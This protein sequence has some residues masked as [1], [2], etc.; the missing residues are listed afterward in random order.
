MYYADNKGNKSFDIKQWN[1]IKSWTKISNGK[2][3]NKMEAENM[4]KYV[5]ALK[6]L[7]YRTTRF[8]LG[9]VDTKSYDFTELREWCGLD[10]TDKDVKKPWWEVLTR[11]FTPVQTEY[12]VRLLKRYGQKKLDEEPQIIID[13]I[14]SVKGG[15]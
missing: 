2:G 5:R 7:E 14:H 11:N 9:C 4:Y 15:E 12:F 1:A 6:D 13:T 3:V 10:M 8:W